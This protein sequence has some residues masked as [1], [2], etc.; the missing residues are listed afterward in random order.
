[1]EFLADALVDR[2]VKGQAM[3]K[4][5]AAKVIKEKGTK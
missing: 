3:F 4:A 1:M 5:K 2:K